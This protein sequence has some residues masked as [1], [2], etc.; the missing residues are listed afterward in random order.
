MAKLQIKNGSR[1]G[2]LVELPEGPTTIGRGEQNTVT[3]NDHSVS[4]QHLLVMSDKTT[5]R[6]KDRG[7]SNGTFVNGEPVTQA[8][9]N[10]GDTLRLGDVE[11]VVILK[12]E[13][14][15]PTPGGALGMKKK[16]LPRM[17]LPV[18]EPVIEGAPPP[19][20]PASKA[21]KKK[22][23]AGPDFAEIM[24][25]A[26]P[27]KKV[28]KIQLPI[29]PILFWTGMVAVIIAGAWSYFGPKK[30]QVAQPAMPGQAAPVT[31]VT[32]TI[33]VPPS[34][35][36]VQDQPPPLPYEPVIGPAPPVLS[37]G[38]VRSASEMGSAQAAVSAAREG[39]A[40]V[41]DLPQAGP[42]VVDKPLTNVQFIGGSAEWTLKAD[43]VNC[44]FFW[45]TPASM[46][47]ESGRLD[48]CAFY[49]SHS[50]QLRLR[51]SDAVSFYYGGAT[52]DPGAHAD[53]PQMR[54]AGFVRGV[55]IHKPILRSG[56][57]E[58]RWDMAWPP[59][60]EMHSTDTNAQG[61][62]SY[63]M[64]PVT[65]GQTAWTPIRIVRGVGVTVAQPVT[66]GNIWADPVVDIN[67]GIDCVLLATAFGG[68]DEAANAGYL[69][70]PDKLKYA[71]HYEWGHNHPNAPF[72]GA[73]ARI[74]GQRN[75]LIG[76]GNLRNWSVGPRMTLPGLHYGDGIIARDPFLQEWSAETVGLTMNFAEPKNV[77]KLDWSYRAA[78]GVQSTS[79]DSG[80]K[81]PMLG[82]NLART[83]FVPLQD[84]R[85]APPTL[86]GKPF[87]DLTGRSGDEILKALNAGQQVFLGEGA[88]ELKAPITNGF[89]FGAGMDRTLLSWPAEVDCA[90]RNCRGLVN[91]TVQGGRYGYN[92]Q[93]GV[94]G[95]TNTA[96][97]LILRARFQDQKQSA[98][99]VHAFEDQVYQDC[100]FVGCR[101]GF[102]QGR[103]KG[104]A[105]W[106]SARG[107]RSGRR[108]QR[109]NIL[110]CRF[111]RIA[112][113]AIDLVMSQPDEGV[114][115]V[116]NC[117]FEEIKGQAIRILGG[118]S[119]VIQACAFSD[120]GVEGS[121]YP[122]VQVSGL[123]VVAV[124][125]LSFEN[126][127]GMGT[128]TAM[129]VDGIPTVS[130]C[131]FGG[132]ETPIATRNPLV[133]DHCSSEEE[134][135]DLPF[136]SLVFMSSFSNAD[137]SKG[138]MEV[139]S[140]DNFKSLSLQARVQPLDITPP[141][142]VASVRSTRT[143]EGN[144]LT[145]SPV[146]DEESG[147]V[148]Y[149]IY[150]DGK[151]IGRTPTRLTPSLHGGNPFYPPEVE[152]EYIDPAPGTPQY[153]VRA[154]NGANL[155]AGVG[156]AP[157]RGW[158]PLRPRFR[159]IN[160]E[161][162]YVSEI[163]YEERR[164]V[165]EVKNASLKIIPAKM[166]ENGGTPYRLVMEQGPLLEASPAPP[167]PPVVPERR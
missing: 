94:G 118:K 63:I 95:R 102:T 35:F 31:T 32:P 132:F 166:L 9:L 17:D 41:F 126:V 70:Q 71:Q 2:Q 64:S 144:K 137:V 78:F 56:E 52:V 43:L 88:Y 114:I 151:Y 72:R 162:V 157:L 155:L 156:Q 159:T 85:A 34:G 54:L 48:H 1:G 167:G 153:E 147:I 76:I 30:K 12:E 92:S 68:Q 61:Y 59:V 15:A 150:A 133:I 93:A 74:G 6:I 112:E 47:Q 106:W 23:A 119:H 120:I 55:T 66:I 50:P 84:L 83:V 75:R 116:Q 51:H 86:N 109:L 36:A 101:N 121:R 8:A 73:V 16:A 44:Q 40:I 10:H 136:G 67:Y 138:V 154:L 19:P 91:L 117:A 81:Y 90:Q 142:P 53:G 82:P 140:T 123:A 62:H 110:N 65:V 69:R 87:V 108:V 24:A 4:T 49:R 164:R 42:V 145:W 165:L 146:R 97:A 99:N 5:C 57:A 141:P 131:T 100:E 39:D 129:F 152:G 18:A 58:P 29:L 3:L 96:D 149:L 27:P 89:L 163:M 113:R 139:V 158:G 98:I 45:H 28:V 143:P 20:R 134:R 25:E 79:A 122:A 77:F 115:A 46:K 11:M 13:R 125:H 33:E 60:F 160:A 107:N 26:G 104:S 80:S 37:S 21:A 135:L 7:S 111:R 148:G 14:Q 130:H 124:S 38:L 105:Y 22:A 127:P 103:L 161:E 128:G